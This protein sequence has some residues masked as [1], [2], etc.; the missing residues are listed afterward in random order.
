MSEA[1]DRAIV[2][3]QIAWWQARGLTASDAW[4]ALDGRAVWSI[5]WWE[6]RSYMLRWLLAQDAGSEK[7]AA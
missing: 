5:E 6:V 3:E 4:A 7:R 2:D 1:E